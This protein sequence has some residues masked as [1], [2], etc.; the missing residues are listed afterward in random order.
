MSSPVAGNLF[1]Q[2]PV[3]RMACDQLRAVAARMPEHDI[4]IMERLMVPKRSLVVSIPVRMRDDS[5]KVFIGYRVQHSLT[6]GASKGGLRYAANVDLGEVG[7]LSM[8]M[9]W[10]CGIMGLPYGGA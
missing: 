1:E 3:Y 4:G 9:S 5:T 10:K 7:A 6:S 8:W 2:S